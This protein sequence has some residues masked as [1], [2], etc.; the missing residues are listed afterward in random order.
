MIV[1]LSTQNRPSGG[2]G[3]R[4]GIK[5]SQHVGNLKQFELADTC[6]VIMDCLTTLK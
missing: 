4:G 1:S 5:H 6:R 3:G 2:R